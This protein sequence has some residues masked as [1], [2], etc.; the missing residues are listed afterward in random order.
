MVN[1]S[2]LIITSKSAKKKLPCKW[3]L[4]VYQPA[5]SMLIMGGHFQSQFLHAVPTLSEMRRL[6]QHDSGAEVK[7]FEDFPSLKLFWS[8]GSQLRM[9]E[10]II[11]L[12]ALNLGDKQHYRWNVTMRWCRRHEKHECPETQKLKQE[13]QGKL[14]TLR[15]EVTQSTARP[16]K[17]GNADSS[18]SPAW[19][20]QAAKESEERSQHVTTARKVFDPHIAEISRRQL[21]AP[22]QP[23]NPETA[24]QQSQKDQMLVTME[25]MSAM[26]IPESF[27]RAAA[28]F[29]AH[30][31]ARQNRHGE[32][33]TISLQLSQVDMLLKRMVQSQAL[34]LMEAESIQSSVLDKYNSLRRQQ[35]LLELLWLDIKGPGFLSCSEHVAGDPKRY[36]NHL[37]RVTMTFESFKKLLKTNPIPDKQL[38]EDGWLCLDFANFPE[39]MIVGDPKKRSVQEWKASGL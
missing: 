17:T 23:E 39:E 14:A 8:K 27:Q 37:T 31:S 38:A 36:H 29:T 35:V 6:V 9:K 26:I 2:L 25:Y 3:A 4:L 34:T 12:D 11:R 28:L 13:I 33:Q 19:D 20:A 16:S 24:V 30:T 10:E 7:I 18:T 32:L 5:N 15:S 21:Q 1:G 22:P